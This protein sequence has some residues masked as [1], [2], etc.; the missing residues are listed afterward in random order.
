M[1]QVKQR[2]RYR[3]QARYDAAITAAAPLPEASAFPFPFRAGL[4]LPHLT[5]ARATV[6]SGE[7][8]T[9]VAHA[10]AARSALNLSLK[11]MNAHLD[12]GEGGI[13]DLSWNKT[14]RERNSDRR[15]GKGR[16]EEERGNI[17]VLLNV[18]DGLDG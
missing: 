18:D 11:F 15:G 10:S 12:S 4:L 7:T 17:L 9:P 8:A 16:R 13:S 1:I 5:F 3:Q 6:V 2:N 14:Y